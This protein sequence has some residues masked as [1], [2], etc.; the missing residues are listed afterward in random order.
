MSFKTNQPK[1]K[2]QPIVPATPPPVDATIVDLEQ[3]TSGTVH[4]LEQNQKIVLG[5][6]VGVLAVIG[7]YFWYGNYK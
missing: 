6:L 4:W 7:G 5:A 3:V 2:P 1:S